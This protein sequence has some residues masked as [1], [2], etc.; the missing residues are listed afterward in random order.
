MKK[1][2]LLLI[3]LVTITIIVATLGCSSS[4]SSS[5]YKD[6]TYEGTSDLGMH[7]GLKVSVTVTDGKISDVSVIEHGETEGI[8]TIAF[9]KLEEA[10]IAAQSTEVDSIS[11]ATKTSGGIK[12]AVNTALEQAK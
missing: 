10:I 12:D 8:G 11:G 7:S 1:I 9:D 3:T 6:G 5:M 4:T 2:K